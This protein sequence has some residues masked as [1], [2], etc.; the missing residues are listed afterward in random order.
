MSFQLYA[1]K[2]TLNPLLNPTDFATLSVTASQSDGMPLDL[3][4]TTVSYSIQTLATSGNVVVA[5]LEGDRLVGLEGGLARVTATAQIEGVMQHASLD[6]VVRPFVREYHQ[7]LTMKLF[8]GQKK[9]AGE[10]NYKPLHTFESALELIKKVDTLT[11]GIPKII[12]L[13]GWQLD[14]HDWYY[15]DW[16]R[17]DPQLKR[18]RDITPVESLRW[19]ICEAREYH[20]TVS[21]HINMF[22]AYRSS[23]LW[24]E[25]VKKDV[26]ARTANGSFF[27]R[28]EHYHGEKVYCV[29]YTREWQEGLA[30]RRIDTLLEM[31]PELVEGGTIHLDNFSA[32]WK[33]NWRNLWRKRLLSEWHARPE[34]GGITVEDE[35]E[36]QRKIYR[37]WRQKGLDVT[38]EGM[39]Q[40]R[41]DAMIGLQPMAWWYTAP[42]R[43]QMHIPERLYARG[44]TFT[45]SDGDFRFGANLHGENLF[46]KSPHDFSA[47]LGKFCR[48]S[49]P[50]VYLSRLERLKFK[51]GRVYYSDGVVAGREGFHRVIRHGDF[52]LRLDDNLFVPA[53]WNE[54]ERQI[55]AYSKKGYASITWRLPDDWADVKTVAIFQVTPDGLL[56]ELTLDIV[57]HSVTLSLKANQAVVVIPHS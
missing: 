26:I 50:W 57:K 15:P 56:P 19:L 5:R 16:S 42:K 37:Y 17:L 4:D 52:I 18:A 24:D 27:D 34:N 40:N 48:T 25:Y 31:L 43:W 28:G 23:P 20:T 32:N 11:L 9:Y 47:F 2:T 30:Q 45:I 38:S 12:Y 51:G 21:L 8:L 13:V 36:S 53:L 29:N 33:G 10:M 44:E 55:I 39:N 49:L 46:L 14:G 35:L 54:P 22:D 7:T 1:D 41:P 6:I 3:K